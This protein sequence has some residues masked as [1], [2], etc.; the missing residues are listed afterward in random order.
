MLAFSRALLIIVVFVAQCHQ[1]LPITN[2]A[3]SPQAND[4]SNASTLGWTTA[5]NGRGTIDIVW[6]CLVTMFLCSW[7]ILCLQVP[8]KDDR[9]R[10]ILWR[11]AWLTALCALG[12]EFTLQL[13]L[14]QWSS[15]RQSC[16]DFHAA[17]HKDWKMKH[18]FYADS[19]GFFLH[20]PDFKPIPIDAKQLLYLIKHEYLE[21]PTLSTADIDDKNKVDFLLRTISVGKILWFSIMLISRG[22]QSLFVSGIELTTAAFI[23][24]SF[25]TTFCWWYKAA[26]V[27]VP[28][29]LKTTHTITEIV[30]KGGPAASGIYHRTPLDFISREEW[31]WSLYWTHWINILR[32]MHISFEKPST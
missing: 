12:P 20:T 6:S 5:P 17:G 19:G 21:Y 29:H 9:T 28:E 4:W 7:S 27:A 23:L 10:H 31:H 13:A 15:A 8:A 30:I 24:C 26:D 16:R 3:P 1:A 2:D 18:A 14:G 11:R 22:A 32:K 25:G